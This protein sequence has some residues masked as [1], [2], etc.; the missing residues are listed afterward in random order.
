MNSKESSNITSIPTDYHFYKRSDFR[1]IRYLVRHSCQWPPRCKLGHC[2]HL[3]SSALQIGHLSHVRRQMTVF[4]PELLVIS[5]FL[6]YNTHLQSHSRVLDNYYYNLTGFVQS[7][8]QI[9]Q[10]PLDKLV[11]QDPSTWL[12][13][14]C[15]RDRSGMSKMEL[16]TGFV[17]ILH[18]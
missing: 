10:T 15:G 14:L 8:N 6:V 4:I 2:L 18:V 16:W 11:H 9:P 7:A 5:F 12:Q 13:F 17:C 3:E 1:S